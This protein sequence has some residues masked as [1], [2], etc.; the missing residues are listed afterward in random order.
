[1]VDPSN[2]LARMDL[3]EIEWRTGAVMENPEDAVAALAILA[4]A[5][6]S[7]LAI[8]SGQEL[9]ATQI[10]ILAT[11]DEFR[12]WRLL[13]VKRLPEALTA[14]QQAFDV[15]QSLSKKFETDSP[16]KIL[17]LLI[18]SGLCPTVGTMGRRDDA[19]QCGK[20]AME[21]ASYYEIHGPDRFSFAPY[22]PRSQMTMGAV[23]EALAN[24]D[25]SA[26]RRREDWSAAAQFY[27]TATG[28]WQ[29]LH[30]GADLIHYYRQEIVDCGR[31]QAECNRKANSS[32]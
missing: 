17:V 11:I 4:S 1:M 28:S 24:Q 19:I 6:E 29:K 21:E 30:G 25:T 5:R 32:V 8:K 3:I 14:F 15:A 13:A 31:K 20:Q 9:N 27:A 26:R 2:R 16:S 22:V 23:Y 10:R 12:G 18:R 7:L